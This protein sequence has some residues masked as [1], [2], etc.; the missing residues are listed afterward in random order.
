MINDLITIEHNGHKVKYDPLT[1]EWEYLGQREEVIKLVNPILHT[2]ITNALKSSVTEYQDRIKDEEKKRKDEEK[3]KRIAEL[4]TFKSQV[5]PLLPDGFTA[6]FSRAEDYSGDIRRFRLK[7][8]NVDAD[9]D[10]SDRV[11]HS[12]RWSMSRTNMPWK[13]EFNFRSQRFATLEKAVANAV[14][15]VGEGVAMVEANAKLQEE[16]NEKRQGIAGELKPLGINFGIETNWVGGHGRNQGYSS[17]KQMAKVALGK[18]I[19]IK[20]IVD[21]YEGKPIF[22]YNVNIEGKFT[23]EQFKKLADFVKALKP[24]KEE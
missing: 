4:E 24:S 17:E 9:I 10:Y 11:S 2:Q 20:G 7:K 3:K 18:E 8:A 19:S 1:K 14:K 22:I 23:P 5:A 15:K 16:E 6:D 21:N 13:V 12:G